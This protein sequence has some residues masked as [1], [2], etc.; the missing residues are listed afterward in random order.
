MRISLSTAQYYELAESLASSIEAKA[1]I[2]LED[3]EFEMVE[4]HLTQLIENLG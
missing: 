1:G 4:E 2:E 3:D